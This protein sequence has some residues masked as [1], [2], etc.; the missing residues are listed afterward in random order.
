MRLTL[1]LSPV[2]D[3]KEKAFAHPS[4][5]PWKL[6]I[7]VER[8]PLAKTARAIPD[9][10]IKLSGPGPYNDKYH[11]S[12]TNVIRYKKWRFKVSI[13]KCFNPD[14]YIR[15]WDCIRPSELYEPYIWEFNPYFGHVDRLFKKKRVK[16]LSLL[17]ELVR[18]FPHP[19]DIPLSLEKWKDYH[20]WLISW[21]ERVENAVSKAVVSRDAKKLEDLVP[22]FPFPFQ[23]GAV[24][25]DGW[26]YITVKNEKEWEDL[27][28]IVSKK[29]LQKLYKWKKPFLR[30]VQISSLYSFW[31]WDGLLRV[32]PGLTIGTNISCSKISNVSTE[33]FEK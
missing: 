10:P 4:S 31:F 18:N 2:D 13:M 25:T 9:V 23:C 7:L 20:V 19:K 16:H 29:I 17:H 11:I 33:E 27:W 12:C 28:S 32:Q 26:G 21:R 6:N 3:E 30:F 14:L 22:P 24:G 15:R 5:V 1:A 8:D